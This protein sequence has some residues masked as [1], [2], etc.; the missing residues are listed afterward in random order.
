MCVYCL[1]VGG[2]CGVAPIPLECAPIYIGYFQILSFFRVF[3][4]LSLFSRA[5]WPYGLCLDDKATP[6]DLVS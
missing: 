2:A 3:Y 1:H 6:I 5:G 4:P